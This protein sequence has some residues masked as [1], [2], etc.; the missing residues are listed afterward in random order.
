MKPNGEYWEKATALRYGRSPE[1]EIR[2]VGKSDLAKMIGR[3]GPIAWDAARQIAH[4]IATDGEPEPNVDP[5]A[6]IQ[7]EQLARGAELQIANASGLDP[8]HHGAGITITPVTRTQWVSRT[9]DDHRRLF[10]SC[11]DV[12]PVELE[13]AHYRQRVALTEAGHSNP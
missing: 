5:L 13:A 6:R 7:L 2:I 1:I 3:Q 12:P 4:S 11:G 9:L 10:E 8:S